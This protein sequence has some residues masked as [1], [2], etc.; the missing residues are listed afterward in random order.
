MDKRPDLIEKEKRVKACRRLI[1]SIRQVPPDPTATE[2]AVIYLLKDCM[3][4]DVRN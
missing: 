3:N 4:N 1:K 2:R